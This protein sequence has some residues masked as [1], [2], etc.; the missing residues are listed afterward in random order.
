MIYET[1]DSAT[2]REIN[3]LIGEIHD[4][5]I[6]ELHETEFDFSDYLAGD[7]DY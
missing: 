5:E 2:L 6:P 1:F 4:F 3:D 7:Y